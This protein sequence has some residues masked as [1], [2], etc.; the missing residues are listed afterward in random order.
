M[1][2]PELA[3]ELKDAGFSQGRV[4]AEMMGGDALVVAQ[5]IVVGDEVVNP[6]LELTGQIVVLQ[7]DAVF[8]RQMPALD[9]ALCHRM[10]GRT[11]DMREIGGDVRIGPRSRTQ[12]SRFSGLRAQR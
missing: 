4:D 5:V 1:I 3:K 6:S 8:E 9:L 7:Q 2:S 12:L 11:A 10:I